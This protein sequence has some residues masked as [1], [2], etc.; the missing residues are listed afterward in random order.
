MNAG[1]FSAQFM[2]EWL[3]PANRAIRKNRRKAARKARKGEP[4]TEQET[5]VLKTP[6]VTVLQG[7]KTY[8]GIAATAIG[9]VLGWVGVGETDSAALSAQI[10]AALD[11]ILTVGGL[12]LAAYGRAKAKPAA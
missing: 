3:D 8:L 10:V 9:L 2:M 5:E 6:E 12:L 11:Q 1:K 4:L 7:K